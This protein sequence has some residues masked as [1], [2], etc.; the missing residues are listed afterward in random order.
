MERT[1]VSET[2]MFRI[3][4]ASGFEVCFNK[5]NNGNWK[6]TAHYHNEQFELSRSIHKDHL[7]TVVNML[8]EQPNA[9]PIFKSVCQKIKKLINK[10]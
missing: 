10:L 4:A 3:I 8:V 7:A 5:H 9:K 1:H 6:A 2:G